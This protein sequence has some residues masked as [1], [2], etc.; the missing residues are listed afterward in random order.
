MSRSM[1]FMFLALIASLAVAALALRSK[2]TALEAATSGSD[3]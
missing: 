2:N 1:R 3:R